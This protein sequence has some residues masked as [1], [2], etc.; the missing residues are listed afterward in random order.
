MTT[1]HIKPPHNRIRGT[2]LLHFMEA[3]GRPGFR[4]VLCKIRV[5]KAISGLTVDNEPEVLET[6]TRIMET[7][8]NGSKQDHT[9]KP[10]GMTPAEII[11]KWQELTAEY[12]S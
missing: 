7:A 11:A 1:N 10:A 9:G 5:L 3:I 12:I 4:G 6:I 2:A 8:G